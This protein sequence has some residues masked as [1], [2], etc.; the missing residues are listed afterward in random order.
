MIKNKLLLDWI[1]EI[2]NLCQPKDIVVWEGSQE[3]Y[4]LT[5][6]EQVKL[7]K[8]I[9]LNPKLRPNSLLYRSDPSDVARVEKRTFISTKNYETAGPTNNWISSDELKPIM[10][11]LYKGSMKGRTMYVIPFS[12]G[13]IGL[14][15][16]KLGVEITDSAY[17]ALNMHIMTRTGIDALDLINQGQPFIKCLHSVGYPLEKGQ[18]DPKWPCAPMDK[19]YIS[20]FPEEE[21]IW[22]YG[23][24]Y[25]G[26]ALLGKKCLALRIASA[27]A[28]KEGWLAEHML[29]LKLTDPNN[30]VKYVTGAFPSACGKTNLAM[31]NPNLEGWDAQTI[32]DDIA[33]MSIKDDGKMYAINPEAGFFG[34]TSGTSVASNPNAMKTI[35]KNTIFT[36]AALTDD[37]DVWWKDKTKDMPKHLI[38]WKGNDWY[39][40]D[41]QRPDHPNARFT[42]PLTNCPNLAEEFEKP[43]Q[44]SA[45]LFGGRRPTTIPLVHQSFDFEHGIFL[46]SIM[47]S[48]ITAATIDDN[49]GKVRRDPFAMLPFIG[50][51]I[52]DYI[53]HWQSMTKKTKESLLPK[54][55]YVNWFRKDERGYLWPGFGDNIRVLKW[56]LDRTENKENY[57]KTAIGYIPDLN[58]FDIEGLDIDDSKMKTLL[59][60]DSQVWLDEV[61]SIENYYNNLYKNTLP[62]VLKDQLNQL[63]ERLKASV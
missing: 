34:V 38:D 9:R 18:V 30:Q 61:R 36:N 41:S 7:G 15:M 45:I 63:K 48:E 27:K 47:G 28:S 59:E 62:M 42:S 6:D 54:I 8:A 25:G 13:P 22:S 23:S 35:N 55:F 44:I 52:A 37:G 51:N 31:I 56:I 39:L 26:N 58:T 60:V 43:V 2:K 29:I 5:A 19:K 57:V 16:S 33:W 4:D 53:K 11:D 46:G 1:E 10:T 20:H 40:G 50:Y 49:I 14:E 17:V 32:G 12:M 21:M 3:Q 24:G